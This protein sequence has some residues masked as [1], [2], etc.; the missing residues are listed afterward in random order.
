M[1]YYG[2]SASFRQSM[3]HA[4]ED[5]LAACVFSDDHWTNG[6]ELSSKSEVI[7]PEPISPTFGYTKEKPPQS[8]GSWFRRLVGGTSWGT[9]RGDYQWRRLVGVGSNWRHEGG[10]LDM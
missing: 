3:T 6:A 2:G 4:R 1:I 5:I 8:V 10:Y 9:S 7:T